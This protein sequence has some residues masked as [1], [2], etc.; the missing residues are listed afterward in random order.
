MQILRIHPKY[1]SD[2]RLNSEHDFLHQLFESLSGEEGALTEHADYF[3]YNGRRGLL[4]ERHRI[5]VEEMITRGLSHTTLIDRRKIE[6][7][8]WKPLETT[9]DEVLAHRDLVK[10]EGDAGRKELP[11]DDNVIELSGEEE[12]RSVL[13]GVTEQDVLFGLWKR[14]RHL[15]MERSYGRYRNLADPIQGK[16]RGQVWMLF[17]LMIEEAFASDPEDGAPRTAYETI[18]EEV[19]E[20]ATAEEKEDFNRLLDGLEPAKVS[21]AM[22]GFLAGVVSRCRHEELLKSQLFKDYL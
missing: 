14:Y 19:E 7:E 10:E 15:V 9:E 16:G 17:D 4:Y 20:G 12:L 3:R 1:Y 8:E 21:L 5:L 2:E 6:P 13:V 22:R 18:W 11:D